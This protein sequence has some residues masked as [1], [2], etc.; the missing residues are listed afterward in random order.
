MDAEK[1][2]INDKYCGCLKGHSQEVTSI[3]ASTGTEENKEPRLLISG[4]RDRTIII[5]KLNCDGDEEA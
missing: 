5:W 3:V 4:S 2:T 1:I